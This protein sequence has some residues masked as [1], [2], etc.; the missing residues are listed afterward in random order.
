MSNY[1]SRS[2]NALTTGRDSSGMENYA[3]SSSVPGFSLTGSRAF[4]FLITLC[5]RDVTEGAIFRQEGVFQLSLVDEELTF[6]APGICNFTIPK[7]S[8]TL[9]PNIWYTLGVMFD[10]EC[11]TLYVDGF[12]SAVP[13]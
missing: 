8:V 4:T 11:I 3:Y 9:M 6:N 13:S 2:G 1:F 7:K 12:K 5:F 10:G